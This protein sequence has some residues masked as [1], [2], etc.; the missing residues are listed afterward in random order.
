MWK[1][2]ELVGQDGILRPIVNRPAA[3]LASAQASRLTI[4]RRF[5]TCRNGP[6]AHKSVMKTN[7]LTV[8]ITPSVSA[9]TGLRRNRPLADAWGYLAA[10]RDRMKNRFS[11]V[12]PPFRRLLL[13]GEKSRRFRCSS[14]AA[15]K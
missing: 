13:R 3:A 1:L 2:H 5:A 7:P 6:V 8:Q 9:G 12:Q 10:S 15:L 4:G 11:T 14:G